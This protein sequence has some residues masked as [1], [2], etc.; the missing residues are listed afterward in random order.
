MEK[1]YVK[2]LEDYIWEIGR[3]FR[4]G[5]RVPIRVLASKQIFDTMDVQVFDQAAN[6]ASLPGIKDYSYVMPDGHSGYGF[7][8]GGVAAFDV[9]DGGII[10]P[11]GIGFDIN[12]GVR[13]MKTSLTYN[14]ARDKIKELVG[15]LFKEVPSGVG[16]ASK[17]KLSDSEFKE[18][19][20]NGT[21]WAIENGYGTKK[22]LEHIELGGKADWA[23]SSKISQR[24]I[25]RGRSQ[26]GTLGSGNHYLEIQRIKEG[27]IFDG[28][29]AKRLGLF[30][31][32]VVIMFHTGSRGG[33][34]QIATDYLQTFLASMEGKYKI[35][36]TDKELASAP[37]YSDDGQDYYKAMGC[38]VNI[39]FANRQLIAS[40]VSEVFGRVFR[41]DPDKLGIS[42][43]YEVAHNRA[44]LERHD[45]DGVEKEFLVH[46]KGATASYYPGRKEIP[47]A[48]RMMGSPVLIGGSMETSSFLLL[49]DSGA[50]DTF[51]STVHG[52]GR[53]MSRGRARK[54]YDGN[55]IKEEMLKKKIY[56]DSASLAGLAEEAGAA[57]KP[58]DE[59]VETVDRLGISR[60]VARFTPVG[61][62]KG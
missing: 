9:S 13:L 24:A 17:H 31:D 10:S 5:M 61:N 34:H 14:E 45:V 40:K 46:R 57:Y 29:V 52:A 19:A 22:D 56:V 59:V 58:V 26:V 16:V 23:D 7:P 38:G 42:T 35:K 54:E 41:G 39:S 51:C 21:I 3:G 53:T 27:D 25:A 8:I 36:V 62:I 11:G 4:K 2:Q 37:F 60:R 49:G 43:V 15:S 48:Y 18:M 47:K 20:E 33:G 30:E 55:K 50:R 44:T 12:C 32:Q 1:K 28:S 6:V